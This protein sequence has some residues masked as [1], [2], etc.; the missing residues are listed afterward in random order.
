MGAS[1]EEVDAFAWNESD[2]SKR[3][4]RL[5]RSRAALLQRLDFDL[6]CGPA[7]L[8]VHVALTLRGRQVLTYEE[9]CFSSETNAFGVVVA[10][11]A[12]MFR[13]RKSFIS[14]EDFGGVARVLF[15]HAHESPRECGIDLERTLRGRDPIRKALS[16]DAALWG[17]SDV[18]DIVVR[19][20]VTFS[21]K[22]PAERTLRHERKSPCVV[23]V[24]ALA[25]I[26]AVED[27]MDVAAR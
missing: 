26:A 23:G 18:R 3:R 4:L 25:V 6:L 10:G 27:P 1:N 12:K 8:R 21:I 13:L 7:A 20:R 9:T 14:G 22:E 17:R 15:A 11:R 19:E 24:Q 5:G 16:S 2:R